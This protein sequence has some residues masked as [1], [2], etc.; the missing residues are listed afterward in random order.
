MTKHFVNLHAHS[1]YSVGDGLGAPSKHIDY[2]ISQGLKAHAFTDHGNMSNVANA[3]LHMR[4]IREKNPD[5]KVIRGVEAYFVPSLTEWQQM[6]DRFAAEAEQDKTDDDDVGTVVENEEETKSGG[7]K[8]KNENLRALRQRGHLVILAKN[9]VGLKNLYQ[10]TS[11]SFTKDNFY[12]YPRIDFEMLK[13]HREGLIVSS[14][15]IDESAVLET[16]HGQISIRSV[17]EKVQSGEHVEVMSF[18][19]KLNKLEFNRVSFSINT[20]KEAEVVRLK[21]KNGKTLLL[22]PDHKVFTDKGWIEAG[23]LKDTPGIKVLSLK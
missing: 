6:K 19:D 1:G 7:G 5:F 21:L 3:E 2:A 18:N 14:A 22:T 15:C 4:K 20:K 12:Y 13:R 16:N 10:L 9:A 11:K 23:S 17:H 8:T